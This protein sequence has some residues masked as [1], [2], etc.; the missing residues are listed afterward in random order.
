MSAKA[1]W[2]EMKDI[3]TVRITGVGAEVPARVVTSLEVEDRAGITRFGLPSGWLERVTGVRERRWAESNVTPSDLAAA[4]SH[5]ALAGAGLA[6]GDVEVL[7]FA[8]ITRDFIEPATANAV[9]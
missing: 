6:P 5:K 9:A 4:A 7:V 2:P 8:G 3:T 1:T